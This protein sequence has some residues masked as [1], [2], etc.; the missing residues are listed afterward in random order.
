MF[1]NFPGYLFEYSRLL[2]FWTQLESSGLRKGVILEPSR[3]FRTLRIF[4]ERQKRINQITKIKRTLG[5]K[6]EQEYTNEEGITSLRQSTAA[7]NQKEGT[8]NQEK[9]IIS[10]GKP[11]N[12]N[13]PNKNPQ[14]PQNNYQRKQKEKPAKDFKSSNLKANQKSPANSS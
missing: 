11:Q 5:I 13:P 8:Q 10:R 1:R 12:Q 14:T 2:L 4:L 7:R 9:I 3:I 6:L